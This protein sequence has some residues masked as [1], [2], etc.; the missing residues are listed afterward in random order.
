MS[1][2]VVVITKRAKLDLQLNHL[3]IRSETVKKIHLGEISTLII[4]STEVSL[5]AALLAELIDWKIKVVFCDAKR[6]P[7]SELL[8]Y[9][10]SHD[11]SSK[12]RQQLQWTQA[13]KDTIWT[14]IVRA[15]I[16]NQAE[17]L[18]DAGCP[19]GVFLEGMLKNITMG[20]ATNREAV[21]AKAYFTALFGE[22]F[23]RAADIY[24]NAA[25]N[26]GYA[27]LLSACNREVVANGYITQ[28][29]I[30]HDNIFNVFN[31]GSDLME[32]LRP[33]LDWTVWK[34]REDGRLEDFGQK[35]KLALIDVLNQTVIFNGQKQVLNFALKK[36]CKSVF[37]ALNEEDISLIKFCRREKSDEK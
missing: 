26:Y 5:T 25:L 8:G 20:D 7:C 29:G 4:E 27:I 14:E 15:K 22:G 31:L 36:Y 37:D 13:N 30:H 18:Q 17:L 21:A 23:S 11:T 24:A 34:L 12:L 28:L 32:P 2:R 6:N 9:Y 3:V 35:E 1:W 33:F 10:G 19:E 16:A